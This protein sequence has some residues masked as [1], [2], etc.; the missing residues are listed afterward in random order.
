V[1]IDDLDVEGIAASE[2]EA[3]AP[4]VIDPDTPLSFPVVL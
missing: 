2:S 1:V 4:L 3:D